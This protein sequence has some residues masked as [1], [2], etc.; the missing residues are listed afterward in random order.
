M[1]E[2]RLTGDLEERLRCVRHER[3]EP[4]AET[5]GEDAD[6]RQRAHGC[7]V[8]AMPRLDDVLR[9][10]ARLVVDAADVLAHHAERQQLDP[11]E[12]RHEDDDRRIADRERDARELQD[13]VDDPEQEGEDRED[14]AEHGDEAQRI[15]RETE[16]HR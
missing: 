2:E 10:L 7:V 9:T 16:R 13:E 4:C 11:A 6:R 12:E 3:A 15:E 14:D 8:E 1:E 5:A